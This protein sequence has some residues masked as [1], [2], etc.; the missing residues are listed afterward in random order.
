MA[1][2]GPSRLA[3]AQLQTEAVAAVGCF[4]RAQALTVPRAR[5]TP[6]R[7][8]E[9]L[10]A[11]ASDAYEATLDHR[12]VLRTERRGVPPLVRLD[13]VYATLEGLQTLT[14]NGP[15]SLR[16]CRS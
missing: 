16:T 14:P 8:T 4:D 7:S 15:P 12:R 10:L 6:S 9:Q 13:R 3:V 2:S 11:L 1:P 5:F